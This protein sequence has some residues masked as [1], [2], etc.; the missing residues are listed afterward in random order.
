MPL[1]GT[2]AVGIFPNRLLM[3]GMV[4][5]SLLFIQSCG[6]QAA[7]Q[8]QGSSGEVAMMVNGRDFDVFA[9][10]NAA[11]AP[12]LIVLHGGLSNSEEFRS[13]FSIV[14]DAAQGGYSVAYMNGTLQGPA[15]RDRRIW[16]A[17]TCCASAAEQNIDDVGYIAA[18]IA[19]LTG[20]GLGD[21]RQV[22]LLG[23]SNGGMM[24]YR[25]AC[26][27]NTMIRGVIA[28]SAPIVI[29]SCRNASGVNIL[30]IHGRADR[31]VP[32]EGGGGGDWLSGQDFTSV[33]ETD[34]ILRAGGANVRTI[35]LQGAGHGT[36]RVDA[37]MR[38]EMGVSLGQ[39]IT[40]FIRG[41]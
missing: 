17:G 34:A 22:Y 13:R 20:Q 12:L 30:H 18:V 36:Q 37:A 41:G 35:L 26:E 1:N 25:F 33:D 6:R 15:R 31:L 3:I 2:S 29:P 40:Q 8:A 14:G 24:A 39:T 11:S 23:N 5:V 19:S 9:A 21:P 4:L 38:S 28:V 27:R 32:V 7:V 16:N 10:P